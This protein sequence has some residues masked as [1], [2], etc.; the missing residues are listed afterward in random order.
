MKIGIITNDDHCLPLLEFLKANR[1]GFEIFADPAMQND[2]GFQAA[3]HFCA[4][5]KV[6]LTYG[7]NDPE[8]LYSWIEQT[9]PDIL[10]VFGYR[11][12]IKTA[13]LPPALTKHTYNIHFGALPDFRGPIPIFWQLKTGASTYDITIHRINGKFDAGPI[14]WSKANPKETHCT[15]G[16]VSMSLSYQAVEGVAYIL[17]HILQ[18]K[19]LPSRQPDQPG[20]YYGRPGLED[21]MIDWIAMGAEEILNLVLACNPWNK[22]AITLYQGK[23]I[24]LLDATAA[25][26]P[27]GATL[28]GGTIINNGDGLRVVCADGL[29]IFV[30][31]LTINGSFIAGRH[32]D[33]FGIAAGQRFG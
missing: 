25:G 2:M 6:P 11:H 30:H 27:A 16:F 18:N 33:K 31:M 5:A 1:I 19:D 22:G 9:K 17:T 29:A 8:N 14:V 3:A 12:L 10:F 13:R 21:V 24:K 4:A 26:Q 28:I 32:A 7:L 23:E 20:R 15:Y